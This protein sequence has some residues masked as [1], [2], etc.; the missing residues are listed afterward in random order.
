MSDTDAEE[1]HEAITGG[2]L[3]GGAVRARLRTG[4]DE[5]GL[6]WAL[7]QNQYYIVTS[8]PFQCD[9]GWCVHLVIRRKEGVGDVGWAEKQALKNEL[10]GPGRVAIEVFP[11]QVDLVDQADAYHLWVLPEGFTLPFS[12]EALF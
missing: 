4:S 3:V 11:A 6:V 1:L 8:V 10:L 12:V 5:P 9:W 7:F 2:P